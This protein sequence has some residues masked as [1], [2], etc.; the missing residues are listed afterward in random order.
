MD[1][2][3]INQKYLHAIHYYTELS[4]T[5]HHSSISQFS[6]NTQV[7]GHKAQPQEE[8]PDIYPTCWGS[9]LLQ[10]FTLTLSYTEGKNKERE[11]ERESARKVE[12][13]KEEKRDF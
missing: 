1:I 3:D 11:R 13:R 8:K 12:K 7:L 9:I 2:M 4:F 10:S 5:I 6:V